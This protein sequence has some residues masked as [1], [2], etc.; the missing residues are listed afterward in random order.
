MSARA[1]G[2]DHCDIPHVR[3][4]LTTVTVDTLSAAAT[5]TP[6]RATA[7]SQKREPEPLREVRTSSGSSSTSGNLVSSTLSLSLSLLLDIQG[8]LAHQKQRP[9]RSL[10]WVWLADAAFQRLGLTVWG[11][12][13]RV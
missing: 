7:F 2:F 10:P 6:T 9:P 12:G 5:P 4:D 3:G 1:Q 13:F 11:S 8:Y